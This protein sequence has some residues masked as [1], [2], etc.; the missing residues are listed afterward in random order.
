[1]LA[2]PIALQRRGLLP[3]L[4][5]PGFGSATG[6]IE[7]GLGPSGFGRSHLAV[8]DLGEHYATGASVRS[9]SSPGPRAAARASVI[10]RFSASAISRSRHANWQAAGVSVLTI[11]EAMR[12][13]ADEGLILSKPRA[14]RAVNAP[15][16]VRRSE[17]RPLVL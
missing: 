1:V 15:E 4:P 17:I 2:R 16:Q 7:Q 13:L 12:L 3:G 10:I 14:D 8:P 11:N 5:V 6:V 9:G